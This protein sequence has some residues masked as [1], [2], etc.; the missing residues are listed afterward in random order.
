LKYSDYPDGDL[1]SQC[2]AGQQPAWEELISRY[3][4][5][6]YST[7]LRTGLEPYLADEIFQ[8]VCMIWLKELKNL[9]QAASLGAWLVTTTRRECWALWRHEKAKLEE[10]EE[11]ILSDET[12]ESI[13][14]HVEDSRKVL[15]A[16]KLLGEP[17]HQLLWRLYFNEEKS[18]YAEIARDLNIPINSIGPTRSRCLE[19]LKAILISKNF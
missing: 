3:E 12:P 9:R 8:N 2:I 5:L 18:S 19:K 11:N 10:L 17:C 1:I 13:T 6:I 16:F 4:K 14:Q 15:S 7:A